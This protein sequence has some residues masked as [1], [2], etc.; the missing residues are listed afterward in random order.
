MKIRHKQSGVVLEGAFCE[1]ATGSDNFPTRYYF[2]AYGDNSQ[3]DKREW[4][5]V[6]PEPKWVDVTAECEDYGG[7]AIAHNCYVLFA[8]NAGADDYRLRKVQLRELEAHPLLGHR[9]TWAF[10]IERKEPA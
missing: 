10:I 2:M 4:E 1:C 5:A 3:Y 6:Q 8:R 7:S 9:R